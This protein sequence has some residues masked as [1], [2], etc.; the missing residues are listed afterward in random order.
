[1]EGIT[2][3]CSKCGAPYF[4]ETGPWHAV[5]PPPVHPMCQ[6]WNLPSTFISYSTNYGQKTKTEKKRQENP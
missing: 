2:G 6:C 1:M 4:Q 5:V 3:H